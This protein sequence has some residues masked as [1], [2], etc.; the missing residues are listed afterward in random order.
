MGRIEVQ[1]RLLG[2]LGRSSDLGIAFLAMFVSFDEKGTL[3]ERLMDDPGLLCLHLNDGS[4]D[5]G[6]RMPVFLE[7]KPEDG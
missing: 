5:R 3:E 4:C 1:S 6:A 2:A 7:L